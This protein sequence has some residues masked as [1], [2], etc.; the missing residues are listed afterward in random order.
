MLRVDQ[1]NKIF[2]MTGPDKVVLQ[3]IT[4]NVAA[5]EFMCILGPSG[6]GKTTLLRCIGGFESF[7]SGAIALEGR[8][9]T[10]PGTER[11][12]IFQGFDQL[13]PWKTVTA[14]LE[15]PLKIKGISPDERR[16]AAARFLNLVGLPGYQDYFPHQL[17]GGMK[18]RA[19]I[20]RALMLEPRVLLMDEPFGNLDAQ[21]RNSLQRELLRIWSELRTMV[22]FV[23]HDIEEAIIL[24]D[25]ILMMTPD[26]GI[27][28]IVPNQLERPRR[29][30]GAGFAELWDNLYS[31]LGDSDTG[32]PE[33]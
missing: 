11:M 15:Y 24:S 4:F 5:G 32:K 14:N 25:R 8:P 1:L 17:S 31:Q 3:D 9:V 29:P 10:A 7:S 19:A 23:T 21:T 13:F 6:C 22:I 12:M 30:G 2:T 28:S 16:A 18:Q 26:G 33:P 27:R 20:A